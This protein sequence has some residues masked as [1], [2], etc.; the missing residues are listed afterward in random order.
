[1]KRFSIISALLMLSVF[2]SS[3]CAQNAVAYAYDACGNR[4]SRTVVLPSQ[5]M[6]KRHTEE[7]DS[8]S[9]FE[10]TALKRSVRIYPNPTKGMLKVEVVGMQDSDVCRLS[11]Y[12]MSGNRVMQTK[13]TESMTFLDLSNYANGHYLLVLEL[14]GENTTWKIIKE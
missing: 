11:L 12:G 8:T 2:S 1:M 6:A 10:E 5:S 3:L 4:V 13:A 14:N 9:Y 7:T